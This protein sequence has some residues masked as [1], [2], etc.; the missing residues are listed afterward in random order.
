MKNNSPRPLDH[1]VLP[2]P[3]LETARDRLTQLGFAVSPDARHSFGSENAMVYFENG[4]FIEP[5]AIGHRETV[6]E[7]IIKGNVFLRRDM[8]YRFR[9]GENGFSSVVLGEADPKKA[10]KA[11]K[12]AG[13]ETGK[14]VT[15]KRPGVKVHIAFIIDERAPDYSFFLCER[16][17]GPPKFSSDITSHANGAKGISQVALHEHLPED[18]QYYM[19]T[20]CLQRE[21]RS[22]SFGM[23]MTLPNATLSTLNDDGMKVFYGADYSSNERGLRAAAFDVTV[24]DIEKTKEVLKN[25]NVEMTMIG[26]RLVVEPANG[27]GAIIAFV[28]G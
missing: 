7:N 3:D 4:T 23:D 15:V 20:A 19:Q 2:V 9:N 8:G 17:D 13:Y 24:Q 21:V 10:R 22:H 16:P 28:E 25:S 12:K 11:F 14:V 18:F 6:E 1:V 27:Q 5:L 26:A